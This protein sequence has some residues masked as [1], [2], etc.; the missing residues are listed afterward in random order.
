MKSTAP[1]VKSV[2]G[3][4]DRIASTLIFTL[5]VSSTILNSILLR[6]VV[7]IRKRSRNRNNPTLLLILSLSVSDLMYS[8]MPM[9]LSAITLANGRQ[10][11]LNS[12]IS[13]MTCNITGIIFSVT[14]RVSIVL[15]L[16]I[17]MTRVMA[18]YS[19]IRYRAITSLTKLWIFLGLI[20]VISLGIATIPYYKS[21]EYTYIRHVALCNWS[22]HK[23][24]ESKDSLIAAHFLFLV[25]PFALPGVLVLVLYFIILYSIIKIKWMAGRRASQKK[26]ITSLR[27]RDSLKSTRS[28]VDKKHP[29]SALNRVVS[30]SIN[31][32]KQQSV[33]FDDKF[34]QLISAAL[35]TLALVGMFCLCYCSWWA[36]SLDFMIM[37]ITPPEATTTKTGGRYGDTNSTTAKPSVTE[38]FSTP[39]MALLGLNI[40]GYMDFIVASYMMILFSASTNPIIHLA[41]VKRLGIQLHKSSSKSKT[42]VRLTRIF[43]RRFRRLSSNSIHQGRASHH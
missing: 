7:K 9:L 8:T 15:I 5:I 42:S 40:P 17:S 26:L 12:I 21:V 28:M 35:A 33:R 34:G 6:A 43:N 11:N 19:P 41:A 31:Y 1:D 10:F 24:F 23:I 30:K 14:V 13:R 18:I 20:W 27:I 36:L 38:Y 3:I 39:I 16:M 4:F 29:F 22:L 32:G 37:Y 25:L 2:P